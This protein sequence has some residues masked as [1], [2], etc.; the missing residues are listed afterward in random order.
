MIIDTLN[1]ANCAT[2][3]SEAFQIGFLS[4]CSLR[5][6]SVCA[7]RQIAYAPTYVDL[8]RIKSFLMCTF[9]YTSKKLGIRWQS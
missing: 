3:S 2:L 1:K 6:L 4:F 5:I 8:A 7:G 9:Y